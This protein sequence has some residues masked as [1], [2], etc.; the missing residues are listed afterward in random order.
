MLTVTVFIF[1]NFTDSFLTKVNANINKDYIIVTVRDG[2]TL[3]NIAKTHKPHEDIRKSIYKIEHL[4][5]IDKSIIYPGQ[6]LK[7]PIE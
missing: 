2:D 7:I 1:T 4:N 6:Q 3:W 5:N